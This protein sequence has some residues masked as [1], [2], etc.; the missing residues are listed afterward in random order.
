[1]LLIYALLYF[2]AVMLT[3]LVAHI[4]VKRIKTLIQKHHEK[5]KSKEV[6]TGKE[7]NDKDGTAT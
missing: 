1:M 4:K 2:S 7:D 3:L 6:E 5:E